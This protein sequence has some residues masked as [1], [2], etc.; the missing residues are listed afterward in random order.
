[1]NSEDLEFDSEFNSVEEVD[2]VITPREDDSDE[3]Y[4][5]SPTYIVVLNSAEII[6]NG[7]CQN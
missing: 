4:S 5:R 6:S 2:S 1:V 7:N 3:C